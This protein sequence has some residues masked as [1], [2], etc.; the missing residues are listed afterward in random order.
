[1]K[2]IF[3]FMKE[4]QQ[5]HH[6]HWFSQHKKEWKDVR[7]EFD[8]CMVNWTKKVSLFDLDIRHANSLG[9]KVYKIFR[10]NR[11]IRF[12]KDKTPYKRNISGTIAID[13]MSNGYPGYYI[14]I[15]PG[16][17]SFVGGGIYL[18]N[19]EAL[20]RIRTKIDQSPETLRKIIN[21]KSFRKMFIDGIDTDLI[22]A[23]TPRGYHKDNP[24]IDL[25][26]LKSFTAGRVFSDAEV[27][28]EDFNKEVMKTLKSLYPLNEFLKPQ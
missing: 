25:L 8:M 2:K 27:L 9:N 13:S 28:S 17:K 4:F 3:S 20:K 7:L 6:K 11:D 5:Y 21:K 1:M 24:G 19:S 14:S 22:V 15:E 12:S 16:N 26:R 10:I 23:T 18:P